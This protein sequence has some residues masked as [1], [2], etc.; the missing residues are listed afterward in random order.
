MIACNEQSERKTDMK[1][2]S[3]L[4]RKIIITVVVTVIIPACGATAD[5]ISPEELLEAQFLAMDISG[6]LRPP[7]DLTELILSDL[8]AIRTAYP[9][10][11]D[12]SY[13]GAAAPIQLIVGLTDQA[14]EQFR[15]GQYHELDQ[16]NAEYGVIGIDP[17][18]WTPAMVLTFDQIYN[19]QMLAD[20]YVQAQ[21]AG[22]RYA[23]SNHALAGDGSTIEADL[24]FYT[25][26]RGW[27]DCPSG[28]IHHEYS[29]FR[30]VDGQVIP[31][32]EPAT[33]S[34]LALGGLA[35]LKKRSAQ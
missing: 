27:G 21:P 23:E 29:Y 31:A 16:L 22:M 8:A 19:P 10:I 25:F 20:I 2:Y 34:L 9:E 28:C 30:V 1:Y 32:P 13:R 6:E 24:P 11:A 3:Q 7:V 35:M 4:W 15:N 5:V 26:I 12:I 14:M 17:L 18:S 33:L